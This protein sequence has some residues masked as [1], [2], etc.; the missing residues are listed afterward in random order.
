MEKIDARSLS[1]DAQQQLRHQAIRLREDGRTYDEIA[2]VVGVHPSTISGWWQAYQKQGMA[3]IEIKKR[4]RRLGQGRRLDAKQEEQ[5]R[6]LLM[7]KTPDQLKLPFALWTRRAVQDLVRR[8][9]SIELPIRTVGDY[10]KRF[11]F[12]PQKP[13]KRAYEQNPKAVQRWLDDEYPAIAKR[14]KEEGAEIHW[15]DET[16]LRND[17]QHGRSYAPRGKTPAIRLSAKRQRINLISSITNQGK[18]RFMTYH[19]KMNADVLIR[20]MTRLIKDAD[21]KTFLVLDNLRVHH[22]KKVKAWLA[23]HQDQI[24]VFYL[25]SYSPEI[26]P[27]EYLNCDLKAGVHSRPPTRAKGDLKRK[28][29]THLRR[30]QKLPERVK[31]YFQHPKIAYA[32]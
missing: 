32:A 23:D 22:S 31:S 9:W 3:G 18:V 7:D 30:V 8:R 4:G 27:D 12:T 19:E 24:E 20:F 5:L 6:R 15:G 17:S 28:T 10:L 26:N 16:G 14:A 2:L 11:G 29:I 1:T 13:L 25:P 21:Q